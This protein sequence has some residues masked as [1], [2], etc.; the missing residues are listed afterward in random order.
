MEFFKSLSAIGDT[1]QANR[2]RND[3]ASALAD[4]SDSTDPADYDAAARR[5]IAQGDLQGGTS[6]AA[7]GQKLVER[8]RA[9]DYAAMING[10]LMG[11][12]QASAARAVAANPAPIAPAA[13]VS[14]GAPSERSGISPP[15]AAAAALRTNPRLRDEF[16]AIYGA[17]AAQQVF[18]AR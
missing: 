7:I 4:M 9:M 10:A 13:S 6:L 3:R 15:R 5:L 14:A 18:G 11:A 1:L 8:K 17:G 12:R 2:M 16:D